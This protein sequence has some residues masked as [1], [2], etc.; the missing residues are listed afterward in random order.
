MN[1]NNW[2]NK[3]IVI[4][5]GTSGLG[6][7]LAIQLTKLKARVAII[8]RSQTGIDSLIEQFPQIIGIQGDI[9]KKEDIYP[10]AGQVYT[11]LGE[12]DGLF[13]V[14]SYLGVTPLRLLLDTDCEDFELVL[15]TN[16]LGPFRL[17]KT[18]MPS[19]LFKEMGL[20]VNISSDAAVNPYRKWGAYSASK[21][22]VDQMSRIFD[23]ELKDLGIRFLSID[24]G[25]MNT[26]MHFA[27]I[28][29]AITSHLRDPRDSANRILRLIESEDFTS[30]RRAV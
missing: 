29:D 4:T 28:P 19:M 20:V 8:A 9:S 15:Q 26:P 10:I 5:G 11:K 13:N 24:P 1:I 2:T 27:A 25:D 22:A 21:A 30:V 18:L 14:A 16:V 7:A 23:E 17:T 6:R 3:R 12:I